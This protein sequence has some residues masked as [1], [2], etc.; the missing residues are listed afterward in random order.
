MLRAE[1]VHGHE[2][3][4][5]SWWNWQVLSG[6]YGLLQNQMTGCFPGNGL[7]WVRGLPVDVAVLDVQDEVL[8]SLAF[9]MFASILVEEDSQKDLEVP[10]SD[11]DVSQHV[12]IVA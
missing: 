3:L 8:A 12:R 4:L 9:E 6:L 2:R 7:I 5:E 11:A 10:G 1:L